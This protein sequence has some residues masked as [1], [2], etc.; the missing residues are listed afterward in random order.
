MFNADITNVFARLMAIYFVQV[1][2]GI[3]IG[4][5]FFYFSRAYQRKF[6][7]SW[8]WSWFAFAV[9]MFGMFLV[10]DQLSREIRRPHTFLTILSQTASFFH[11][12]FLLVGTY[13]F[14]KN[15]ILSKRSLWILSI[16]VFSM[17]L[18][19]VLILYDDP[20][21]ANYRYALRYGLR[22]LLL[23]IGFFIAA[24]FVWFNASFSK[25]LGQ[26]ALCVFFLLYSFQQGY[27][28]YIIVSNLM[29]YKQNIPSLFGLL[30]IMIIAFIGSCMIMWLLE[31]EREKLRLVNQELDSFLYSTS[32]DLRAPLASILGLTNLAK[33]DVADEKARSLITMIEQRA[34]KMDLVIEDILSLARSKKRELK[35]EKIDFNRLVHEVSNDIK[36]T[37]GATQIRLLYEEDQAN[38]FYS[39][40]NQLKV[41]LGNLL[42]NAVKYH[43][44]KQ[45]DPIIQIVLMREERRTVLRVIDNGNGIAAG[46]QSRIFEMFYRASLSAEGTGLGLYITKEAVAKLGGD[47][48][49]TSEEGKGTTFTVVLPHPKV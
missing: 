43:N 35:L 45:A 16:V 46:S 2:M 1:I 21:A 6:L 18:I 23:S 44:I 29:G 19:S 4:I 41:I 17:S 30:D 10:S 32:H 38:T 28:T 3:V 22:S 25:G 13:E 33:Y 37:K 40:I 7:L 48:S 8:A 20:A 5:T 24:S 9:Y 34:Q 47:I 31:N 26:K 11:I 39:D 12:L 49:F 27:Y 14:S 36:F 42:S 15:Q